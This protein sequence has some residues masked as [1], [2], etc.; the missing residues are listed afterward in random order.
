MN[1][2]SDQNGGQADGN[3]KSV[4]DALIEI[5]D[6]LYGISRDLAEVLEDD[7]FS[8]WTKTFGGISKQLGDEMIRTA[9]AG[10]IKSGK[11]TFVNAFLGGDYLKRGAGVVTSVVTRI[12]KGESFEARLTFKSRG[13]V[14]RE[15]ERAAAMTPFENRRR[16]TGFDIADDD[17]REAMKNEIE[18]IHP[19]AKITGDAL[20]I[21]ILSLENFLN[22]YH[23]VQD[24]IS[25]TSQELSFT[26]GS[27]ENHQTYVSDDTLAVYLKDVLLMVPSNAIDPHME[28][29]DCQGSDSPNPMH[30]SM[31]E[32]YLFGTAHIIYVIS[33]RT[34][35]RRADITFLTIIKKMGLADRLL[36]IVN[37]DF[38]EH[39][40]ADELSSLIEKIKE[41]LSFVTKTPDLFAISSLFNLFKANPDSLSGKDRARYSAWR[42]D[43]SL[44]TFSDTE[45]ERFKDGFAK[46]V[47][48]NRYAA[49]YET[50]AGRLR[51]AVSGIQKRVRIHKDLITDESGS[52][53][54]MIQKIKDSRRETDMIKSMIRNTIDGAVKETKKTLAANTDSF[55]DPQSG[56]VIP[57]LIKFIDTFAVSEPDF[58]EEA[59]DSGFMTALYHAFEELKQGVDRYIAENVNPEVIRF[60]HDQEKLIRV[61]LETVKAP[62]E[63]MV[64][65][66]TADFDQTP[67]GMAGLNE[68]SRPA[69]AVFPTIESIR[70]ANNAGLPPASAPMLYSVRVKTEAVFHAGVYSIIDFFKNL[71]QRPAEKIRKGKLKGLERGVRQVKKET[72]AS[73]RMHYKDYRENLKYQYLFKLS[74]RI[75]ERLHHDLIEQFRFL[76][77]DLEKLTE[78]ITENRIDKKRGIELLTETEAMLSNLSGQLEAVMKSGDDRPG[79]I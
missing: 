70:F 24:M 69:P 72:E 53:G 66:H 77:G 73:I 75:G 38:N 71:I 47:M 61:S 32:D 41:E 55:F 54:R 1:H 34:G 57:K 63:G 31:I 36:F 33:S 67:D 50:S 52:A 2:E 76:S 39:E 48:T 68:N 5:N 56:P 11:S 27:F 42:D 25:G 18:G 59:D 13:E 10:P 35:L 14:N 78:K 46:K 43:R 74:D 37:V 58:T 16:E 9:V 17:I 62:Y 49:L 28:I 12:R 60:I 30:L 8:E 44:S 26:N 22:G 15:I 21:N 51:I 3:E 23:R 7:A 40:S 19:D 20:N 45:T 4:K 64:R 65:K 29:A 6:A 79:T